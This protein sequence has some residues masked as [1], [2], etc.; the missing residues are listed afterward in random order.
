MP[1]IKIAT[2]C[3]CGTKAALVLT[4]RVNH[5]LCCG[6]CGAP[7]RKLKMLP[8]QVATERSQERPLSFK[9]PVGLLIAPDKKQR[10]KPN[11]ASKFKYFGRKAFEE[12]WDVVEGIFD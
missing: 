4:G 8:K 10:K 3:Y 7:L 6:N 2:C 11:K 1:A 12:I 5:E 9:H